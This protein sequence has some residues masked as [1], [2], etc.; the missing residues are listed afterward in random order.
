M[1][2]ASLPKVFIWIDAAVSFISVLGSKRGIAVSNKKPSVDYAAYI[3]KR[4]I[5]SE[6]IET[7]SWV[8]LLSLNQLSLFSISSDFRYTRRFHSHYLLM[9]PTSI[10]FHDQM[11][12]TP[13]KKTSVYSILFYSILMSY[14]TVHPSTRRLTDRRSTFSKSDAAVN[15]KRDRNFPIFGA[16]HVWRSVFFIFGPACLSTRWIG[17][18]RY[19]ATTRL[20]PV[21]FFI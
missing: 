11:I 3:S 14:Q 9:L 13:Y 20:P 1:I 16:C 10:C 17:N 21:C 12:L 7:D 8:G 6:W 18:T 2:I 4:N 5:D 15:S 19:L